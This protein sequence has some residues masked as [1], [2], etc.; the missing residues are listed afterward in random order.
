[1][2]FCNLSPKLINTHGNALFDDIVGHNHIKRLF[3][4]ALDSSAIHILLVGPPTSAK[5]MFLTS[6]MHH[7]KDTYFADG[8]N[9]TKAGMID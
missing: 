4:M 9:S 3:R 5:T 7:V 2:K 8:A 6:L 1:M